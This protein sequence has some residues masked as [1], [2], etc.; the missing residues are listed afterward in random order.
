MQN[1]LRYGRFVGYVLLAALFAWAGR[2]AALEAGAAK[3]EITPPLGTPLNGY[4]DRMGRGAEAVHDPVWARCLYLN[5]GQTALFLVNADLCIINPELRDHVLEM[6][7]PEV[8]AENIILTATHTHSAQGGMVQSPIFRSVSG[9]FMPEILD[10]TARRITE[11]MRAAYD[12]RRPAAIG[13]GTGAQTHLSSNRR[14]SGG[15]RDEQLGV[16]RVDDA[17][18]N[19]I[20]IAANLAAHPTTID[21]PDLMSVSADYVGFYYNELERLA[22]PGCVAMFFNGAEGNQTCGNPGRAE[23]WGRTESMGVALAEETKK[24]ANTIRCGEGTLTLRHATPDLPRSMV[25]F[26]MPSS[27]LLQTLEINDLLMTFVPGEACVEIGHGLRERALARG[28]T[29]QF[30]VGLS[31]NFLAYFVPVEYYPFPYY[32]TSMNFYGPWISRWYF[33]QFSRLMTRG[34][35][36][37]A[38]PEVPAAEVQEAG[39]ARRI[40]L[41]GSPYAVGRQRGAAFK[42]AIVGAY[43]DRIVRAVDAKEIFPKEG[44]WATVSNYLY[45]TDYSLAYLGIGSRPLLQGV[46]NDRMAE[47]QGMADGAELPFDALWLVQC[48]PTFSARAENAS[49]FRTAFCTMFASVGDRAGADDLLVARNLDWPAPEQP[50]IVDVRPETGHRFVQ[51]G[52][53]WNAGVF[54][55]M[56]DA[57][58]VLCAERM[59]PLGEPKTEGLPVEFVLREILQQTDNAVDAVKTLEAQQHLQGYLVLVASPQAESATESPSGK[60][61]SKASASHSSSVARVVEFG[62]EVRVREPEQGLLLGADPERGVVSEAAQRRYTRIRGLLEGEHIVSVSKMKAALADSETGQP[63]EARIWSEKTAHSIVFEPRAK[64]LHVAFPDE[65]GLPGEY[66]EVSLKEGGAS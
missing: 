57:G 43:Q 60:T 52:F 27:V 36:E 1:R 10:H 34:E 21:G 19:P 2:G 53:P 59:P 50:V 7:P 3:V 49:F 32:E 56:N 15:P 44:L 33:E 66:V 4:G 25:P 61:A 48:V 8:P 5:D 9:R 12:S 26:L 13:Y 22:S 42:E 17:D 38:W 6:A 28:Y 35:P 64:K 23:G 58:L 39:P 11:A 63:Q 16:L 65:K 51:V 14:V 62:P 37:A 29:T 47:L 18:G 55:G 41:E 54:S 30:T 45:T 31:N 46:T 20:A 40:V 24:V